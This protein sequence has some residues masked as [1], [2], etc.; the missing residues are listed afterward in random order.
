MCHSAAWARASR[1]ACCAHLRRGLLHFR[2]E[3]PLLRNARYF[4]SRQVMPR[5]FNQSQTS[6][7]SMLYASLTY[8]PPGNTNAA[9]P[10]VVTR[11]RRV[12]SERRRTDVRDADGNLARHDA[13]CLRRGI[14]LRPGNGRGLRISLRPQRQGVCCCAEDALAASRSNSA[15]RRTCVGASSAW[16]YVLTY[17]GGAWPMNLSAHWMKYFMFGASVC[18]RHRAAAPCKLARPGGPRSQAASLPYGSHPR[19]RGLWRRAA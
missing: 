14:S 6:V 9:A 8:D 16:V 12:D 17:C 5:E 1:M 18:N 19:C 11:V 2:E 7:P 3:C 10:R 4:T 15:Q 13:V